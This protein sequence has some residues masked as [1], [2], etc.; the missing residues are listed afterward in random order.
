MIFFSPRPLRFESG[1]TVAI[2]LQER[3]SG[4]RLPGSCP[5]AIVDIS[6]AG[7]CLVPSQILLEGRHLFFSTLESDMYHL[8]ITV[9][10][11][12]SSDESFIISARSV[13]MNSCRYK[14]IPA[15]K[16]GVCFI[17]RQK[18]LFRLFKK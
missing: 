5:G 2:G 12:Q 13:W 14:K 18:K 15:F 11:P 16:V 3:K 6:E 1:Y 10:N 7:A 9:D 8:V 4:L 17:D